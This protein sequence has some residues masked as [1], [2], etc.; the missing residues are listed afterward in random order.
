MLQVWCINVA[1]VAG[2]GSG[3]DGGLAAAIRFMHA[4]SLW[5][6]FCH[7]LNSFDVSTS[8]NRTAESEPAS[9]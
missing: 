9:Y 5:V 2:T 7:Q 4:A 1:G 8:R 3:V 6:D